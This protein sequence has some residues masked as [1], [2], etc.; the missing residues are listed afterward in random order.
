MSIKINYASYKTVLYAIVQVQTACLC[1][2]NIQ[3]CIFMSFIF[4][5]LPF[6]DDIYQITHNTLKTL[7][8]AHTHTHTHTK[9]TLFQKNKSVKSLFS[10][11]KKLE[12]VCR[13]KAIFPN[14]FLFSHVTLSTFH[15]RDIR[16]QTE[17]RVYA[18]FDR[19][20]LGQKQVARTLWTL[21]IYKLDCPTWHF[22]FSF[23][24]LSKQK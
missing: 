13:D 8:Y 4:L 23:S 1:I 6:L 20:R 24:L 16:F 15:R 18:F 19:A 14:T 21:S 7:L 12:H 5:P 3:F 11:F 2:Y 22:R 17:R 9:L 10:F